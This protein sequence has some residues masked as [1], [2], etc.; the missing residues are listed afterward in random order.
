M[1]KF[2][3]STGMTTTKVEEYILDL[4]ELYLT[5][6][7]GDIPFKPEIGFNFTLTNVMKDDLEREIVYRLN[8]L[9]ERI[10]SHI[11]SVP[12]SAESIQLIDEQRVRVILKINGSLYDG[13]EINLA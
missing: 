8:S 12:I 7:P 4:F 6:N 11:P 13:L 10:K 3:L 2:L 9:V 5:V 1:K